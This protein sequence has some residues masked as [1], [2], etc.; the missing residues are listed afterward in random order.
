M[1]I[2]ND[3]EIRRNKN[4]YQL[5]FAKT[6]KKD[7]WKKD[8]N[9]RG[10]IIEMDKRMLLRV[11]KI[12]F[13]EKKST[14]LK[15]FEDGCA[16]FRDVMQQAITQGYQDWFLQTDDTGTLE[17][18]L[19]GKRRGNVL[20]DY[21]VRLDACSQ[22]LGQRSANIMYNHQESST[23]IN[24][25]AYHQQH[26]KKQELSL[27]IK[28]IEESYREKLENPHA[29]KVK[30]T[31]ISHTQTQSQEM[32]AKHENLYTQLCDNK[33]KIRKFQDFTNEEHLPISLE[34]RKEF[35][36]EQLI[37]FNDMLQYAC[38]SNNNYYMDWLNQNFDALAKYN[39]TLM[40]MQVAFAVPPKCDLLADT[41][42]LTLQEE[43]ETVKQLTTYQQ[44][45]KAKIYHVNENE[46]QRE[47]KLERKKL[48][49][50]QRKLGK[51]EKLAKA[52]QERTKALQESTKKNHQLSQE[53]DQLNKRLRT[54]S[55]QVSKIEINF[56]EEKHKTSEQTELIC[57]LRTARDEAIEKL[58][59]Q[60]VLRVC[61]QGECDKR[62][63]EIDRLR[64]QNDK[65]KEILDEKMRL[66]DHPR[67]ENNKTR[68]TLKEQD[69]NST[70]LEKKLPGSGSK[71]ASTI[72]LS[73]VRSLFSFLKT[74]PADENSDKKTVTQSGQS[75][76]DNKESFCANN[77]GI[78]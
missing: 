37:I 71:L 9:F 68:S 24:I 26:Y 19:N 69:S 13:L 17:G 39:I 78:Y 45:A 53:N 65:E 49:N 47:K 14:D 40:K 43:Q 10:K 34:K 16:L 62:K 44:Q 76:V 33:Q 22:L 72:K 55:D 2:P 48:E 63:E 32:D 64:I 31:K 77:F 3:N 6:A 7:A 28:A 52:L 67:D 21:E 42:R 66:M 51:V 73:K 61:L 56:K 20:Q 41:R 8:T 38:G 57:S 50:A 58:N 29:F 30:G 11:G 75:S 5:G 27:K 60:I 25:H 12:N 54:K 70:K 1:Y 74:Q 35:M 18:N 23:T 36:R 15:K 4:P 59:E 46:W